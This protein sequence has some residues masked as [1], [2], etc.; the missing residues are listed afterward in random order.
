M[1]LGEGR[2]RAS[3][4]ASS[5]DERRRTRTERQI[6]KQR[7]ENPGCFDKAFEAATTKGKSNLPGRRWVLREKTAKHAD[8]RVIAAAK[9]VPIGR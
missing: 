6:E 2:E 8:A 9:F 4:S 5:R 1:A 7:L 3:P